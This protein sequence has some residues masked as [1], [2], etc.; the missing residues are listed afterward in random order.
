MSAAQGIGERI[1]ARPV[2]KL[3]LLNGSHDRETSA[4][5]GRAGPMRAAD[6]V[7]AVV[8]ALNR[9]HGKRGQPLGF[10]PAAYVTAVLAPAGGSIAADAAELAALGIQCVTPPAP[11]LHV[12]AMR[13]ACVCVPG[14]ACPAA[15]TDVC[16]DT[17]VSCGVSPLATDEMY[18]CMSNSHLNLFS[19][20][21]CLY[22]CVYV[23]PWVCM[24]CSILFF[25]P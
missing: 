24:D 18:T 1:A 20:R 15:H 5:G 25:L 23:P 7:L 10:P 17:L 14:C 9:R 21:V 6:V 12:C 13:R 2:P 11:D 3:L 16:I 22:T 4:C 8:D 19:V